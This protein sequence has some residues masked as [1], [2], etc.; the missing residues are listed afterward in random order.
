MEPTTYEELGGAQCT[1]GK[2]LHR[3]AGAQRGLVDHDT[4]EHHIR[5]QV[6]AHEMILIGPLERQQGRTSRVSG[7]PRFVEL[8]R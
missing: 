3:R 5:V 2:R 4:R 6:K 8:R 7:L 1:R